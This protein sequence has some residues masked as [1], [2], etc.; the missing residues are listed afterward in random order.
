[1]ACAE[2]NYTVYD[3][4]IAGVAVPLMTKNVTL[5]GTTATLKRGTVLALNG[6]KYEIVDTESETAAAKVANAVLAEDVELTGSDAV[7]TVY[8]AG[9]FNPGAMAVKASGDTVLAHE[10]ELRD[11]GIYLAQAL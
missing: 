4:L 2:K 1:M 11:V 8:T 7:A 6:G 10:E 5:K 9:L 3:K